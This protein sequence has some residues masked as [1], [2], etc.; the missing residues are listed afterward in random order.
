[1]HEN[2]ERK[3][4]ASIVMK[5]SYR[6]IVA[7]DLNFTWL[8]MYPQ[9]THYTKTLPPV[10]DTLAILHQPEE[11]L[12]S[13]VIHKGTYNPKTEILVKWKGAPTEDTTWEN[14][15]RF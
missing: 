9:T 8:R 11:I 14:K 5:S 2:A 4:F 7:K 12:Q 10:S 6:V 15:W 3:A 1:M 13:R